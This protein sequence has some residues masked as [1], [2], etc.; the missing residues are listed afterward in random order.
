MSK[1]HAAA[2]CRPGAKGK[3]VPVETD[4]AHVA[5][6]CCS[7]GVAM[8]GHESNYANG[9]IQKRGN[10]DASANNVVTGRLCNKIHL[11]PNPL[12]LL[13]SNCRNEDNDEISMEAVFECNN[14]S[15]EDD[16]CAQKE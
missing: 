15:C 16:A 9:K 3:R 4:D 8:K 6:I 14:N 1:L 5:N 7:C 10:G 2:S 11:H 12:L 13:C